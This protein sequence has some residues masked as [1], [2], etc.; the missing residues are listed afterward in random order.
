MDH[1][2]KVLIP[3]EV[4]SGSWW[5]ETDS[6]P[7]SCTFQEEPQRT[8]LIDRTTSQP[9]VSR[10]YGGLYLAQSQVNHTVGLLWKVSLF[11][12]GRWTLWQGHLLQ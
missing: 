10:G 7:L 3:V 1:P 9:L 5:S 2:G 8:G 12:G 11:R 4:T 6:T